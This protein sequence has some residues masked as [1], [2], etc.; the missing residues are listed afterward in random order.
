M[1]R[2]AVVSGRVVTAA[3]EPVPFAA[4]AVQRARLDLPSMSTVVATPAPNSPN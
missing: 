3:G 4:P 2:G 1:A